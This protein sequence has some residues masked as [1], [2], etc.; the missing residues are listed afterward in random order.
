MN[1]SKK[2]D[3]ADEPFCTT[4]PIKKLIFLEDALS[5]QTD[6]PL[7]KIHYIIFMARKPV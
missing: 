1:H 5:I 7:F 2:D 4:K 6:E 3:P